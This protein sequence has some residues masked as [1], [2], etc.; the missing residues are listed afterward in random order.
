MS[1][2]DNFKH[3]KIENYM[4][5]VLRDQDNEIKGV[6]Q[7]Y[8]HHTGLVSKFTIKKF[9]AFSRFFGGMLCNIENKTICLT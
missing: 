8:N 6:A 1:F 5:S 3:V 9:E 4:S 2:V 7:F